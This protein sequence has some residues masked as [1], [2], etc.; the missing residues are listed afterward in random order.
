MAGVLD[1]LRVLDLSW[2][3][4]GPITA[5][6]LAD[7]GAAV[8][9]VE[10][11][12]ADPFDGFSGYRVW[13]RGKRSAEL[14]LREPTDL[15]VF[16]ALV[17]AA[18]VLVE[19][20][21]PGTAARLGISYAELAELNPRLVHCSI[22]GYGPDGED[23]DRPGYD[24]LVAAR[25]GQLWEHRGVTGGTISRLSGSEPMMAGIEPPDQECWVGAPRTGPLFS[26]VPWPSIATAYNATLAVNT[27]LRARERTG[28]GQH[29]QT[30]L[31]QGVLA[32]TIGPWQRVERPDSPTFQSWVIDP[33][34]PKG[35]YQGSDGRWLHH[36]VP[37]PAFILG[38][39]AAADSAGTDWQASAPRDAVLRIGVDPDDMIIL[40]HY[41]S[42][43]R[44]AVASLPSTVWESTAAQVGVPVQ[45]VRSPEEALLDPALL[46]DGCVVEVADPELGPLRQV[47]SVVR[48]SACPTV[49]PG[50]APTRGQHTAEVRAEAAAPISPTLNSPGSVTPPDT[51][52]GDPPLAGVRVLDLGLAVAGPFGTQLLSDLGADV[53]KVNTRHDG[54]WFA[55]HIA[56]CCNRGKRSIALDLKTPGGMAVLHRL[57]AEADIVQHNMR[58]PAAVR[59][60][61]DHES[62][63]EIK[64]DLIYCH[65]RGFEH[66]ERDSRP[67]NDQ[68]G[69]ALAGTEWLDGGTDQGGRPL[70]SVCSAGDTGNGYLS[71]I[72]M[73]Q[74]LYHRDRTGEGQFVDTSILY[75][76]LLNASFT[77]ST[78][79]GSRTADRPGLD[80]MQLGWNALYGLYRTGEGWLCL[81]APTEE[82][83]TELARATGTGLAGDPRFGSATDRRAND[84]QLRVALEE[85][86]AQRTAAEWLKILD[87]AGVPCETTSP[88][89]VTRLFDGPELRERGWLAGYHHPVMG[90]MEVFG[91]L[92]DLGATPGRVAGPPPLVGQHTHELL[93]EVGYGP[94]EIADLLAAQ[95]AF[96]QAGAPRP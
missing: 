90:D 21:S 67:G 70:W 8:T 86:F 2:G 50:P 18:D 24:G 74:A 30:S 15:E 20:F 35:F 91:L 71:A 59:L 27:A 22:T 92:A 5:M 12:G 63:K 33:R 53:I 76:Q 89:S 38:T 69:A 95:A 94:A 72:G 68:T 32:N 7:H 34:A 93:A 46:A 84:A 88:D 47:G 43:L 36:W 14:D 79:D 57:V 65:T 41:D 19:S 44:E 6:L 96:D 56:M 16:R 61:I 81:A 75:A 58:Y 39:A 55:S 40:Q 23:A 82:H 1:G 48:L 80:A 31:L 77:W 78:P 51:G 29:V 54:Y 25:T 28:R 13:H 17:A 9:R 66:G 4:A 87:A 62:L 3:I 11:P 49:T 52:P 64:P 10:R 37:L 45:P 42:E 73:V 60:G 26:G 83:W 85:V